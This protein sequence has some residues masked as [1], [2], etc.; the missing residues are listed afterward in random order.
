[1]LK[2]FWWVKDWQELSILT[3][4]ASAI[5]HIDYFLCF[6]PDFWVSKV[7]VALY[8]FTSVR[9]TNNLCFSMHLPTNSKALVALG[10]ILAYSVKSSP[11]S[12]CLLNQLP[13]LDRVALAHLLSIYLWDRTWCSLGVTGRELKYEADKELAWSDLGIWIEMRTEHKFLGSEQLAI[14][15]QDMASS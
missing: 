5:V 1:M 9:L 8:N 13:P 4:N 11:K 14:L 12:A 10:A 7:H 6:K 2:L 15:P 3:L